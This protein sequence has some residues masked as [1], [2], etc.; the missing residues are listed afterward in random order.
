[1]GEAIWC[2]HCGCLLHSSL[3]AT[4]AARLL[5]VG[6][7]VLFVVELFLNVHAPYVINSFYF[8]SY[9]IIRGL[10]LHPSSAPLLDWQHVHGRVNDIRWQVDTDS[11]G[12]LLSRRHMK[13]FPR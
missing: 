13:V 1:M 2:R 11:F 4:R 8:I 7:R 6:T 3:V 10:A 9:G 5:D 12:S